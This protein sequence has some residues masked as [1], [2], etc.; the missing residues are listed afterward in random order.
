RGRRLLRRNGSGL[1]RLWRGILGGTGF[2]RRDTVLLALR[3][4]RGS[5]RTSPG[6]LGGDGAATAQHGVRKE[7]G[8]AGIEHGSRQPQR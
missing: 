5:G 2:A 8:A 3:I 7:Y 1:S 4:R 6:L